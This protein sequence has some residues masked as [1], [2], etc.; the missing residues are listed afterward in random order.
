[1][2]RTTNNSYHFFG[3][4]IV[5]LLIC[6]LP[7]MAVGQ[8]THFNEYYLPPAIDWGS[9]E[10]TNLLQRGDTLFA[11]GLHPSENGYSTY[12][13][14]IDNYG[15]WLSAY[16]YDLGEN[17]LLLNYGETILE[18]DT[19][20]IW[21]GTFATNGSN[22]I[23][24]KMD[25]LFSEQWSNV[26]DITTDTT[27]GSWLAVQKLNDG[28][29]LCSGTIVYDLIPQ[30]PGSN[31]ST[32]IVGKYSETGE[33]LWFQ[34]LNMS[35][36]EIGQGNSGPFIFPRGG[37][38][39]LSTGEI[40]VWGIIYN[41]RDPLAIKLDM[42]GNYVDAVKWGNGSQPDGSP[43]P[44][45]FGNDE[46]LFA[47]SHH[48]QYDSWLDSYSNKPRVGRLNTISMSV[49]L[50][51][52]LDHPIANGGIL[53]FEMTPDSG[54]V[55]LAYGYDL[56]LLD[57][58][59]AYM[60]KV[61]SMGN[62]EW[63]H[64]YYP[65]VEYDTPTTYDLEVTSDG[66]LAFVGNFHVAGETYYVTWVVKTDA[67]GYEEPS[68]CPPITDSHAE[69]V[70]ASLQVWPNPFSTYLKA[71]LPANATSMSVTDATGR[72]V[73]SEPVFY[74]NQTWNLSMLADGVYVMRVE[75]VGGM[76]VSSR[77]VKQ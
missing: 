22:P 36:Y 58:G 68:G 33:E 54:F 57:N 70:S 12:T 25:A 21:A 72:L 63:F 45:P 48:F 18:L 19:G 50:F 9:G 42:N 28:N 1:M 41:Q 17:L 31:F 62:E 59:R 61:D 5:L 2:Q 40:L 60:L 49:E 71:V 6:V 52:I 69:L 76:M 37:L 26:K 64:E 23:I 24:K 46:F 55:A 56:D 47:Y 3:T 11:V 35:N 77:I 29:Y 51:P 67:C 16:Q 20:Y 13:H 38:T 14:V 66:G 8:Y 73:F 10:S 65:P 53:D 30:Q 75:M 7:D 15:N 74:P 34:E 44:V 32:L 4:Q 27:Y 39:E 43:W